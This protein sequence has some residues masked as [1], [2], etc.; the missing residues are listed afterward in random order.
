[1]GELVVQDERPAPTE[2]VGVGGQ[3]V[4]TFNITVYSC[5]NDSTGAYACTPLQAAGACGF[6][7]NPGATGPGVDAPSL[8]VACGPSWPCGQEFVLSTGQRVICGDRGG[9]VHDRHLDAWCFDARNREMCL[10]GIGP[11]VE[12]WLP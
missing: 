1:V 10:P 4:G 6:V 8:Y 5:L 9:M 7:L 2:Q 3:Y 12:V 11:T